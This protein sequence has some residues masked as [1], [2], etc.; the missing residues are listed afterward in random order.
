[1]PLP[2][3]TEQAFRRYEADIYQIISNYPK[4]SY[5][6]P[7]PT[8]LITYLCRLRD[9]V[10]SMKRHHYK[11]NFFTI[12]DANNVFKCLRAGGDF[13]FTEEH[14]MVRVGPREKLDAIGFVNSREAI[15]IARQGELDARDGDLLR[16]IL[17]LKNKEVHSDPL[18]F[19]NLTPDL[20]AMID[21]E[22]PNV[23][24]E[25]IDNLHHVLL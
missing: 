25:E 19:V 13:V 8:A 15:T 14:G 23:F 4:V 20:I 3:Q 11:S 7:R 1:M 9:A 24:V 5:L 12:D 10:N 2:N 6:D 16:A 22:Y 21:E 17:V 18:T